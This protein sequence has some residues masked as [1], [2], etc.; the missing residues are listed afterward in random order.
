[1]EKIYYAFIN[2][3]NNIFNYKG[4]CTERID[5]INT[6][7]DK[8]RKNQSYFVWKLLIYV[9]NQLNL[10]YSLQFFCDKGRWFIKDFPICFG[11]SHSDNVVAV[12]VSDK[13]CCVDV[14]KLSN[15]ALKLEKRFI[16]NKNIQIHFDALSEYEKIKLLTIKWCQEECKYKSNSL[17]FNVNTVLIKDKNGKEFVLASASDFFP[18]EIPLNHII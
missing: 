16:S 9:L 5:Y 18:I 12:M 13:T 1:M 17:N 3:D 4:F 2:L 7:S 10:P 15:K 8:K 14:E 11:L 6:I